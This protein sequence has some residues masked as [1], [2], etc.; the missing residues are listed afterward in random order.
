MKALTLRHLRPELARE[1]EREA[2]EAGTSLS[3]A[4]VSLL[5]QATGLVKSRKPLHHDFDRFAG[6]WS[7]EQAK[8]F[9]KSLSRL[10]S[11]DKEMWK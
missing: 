4:V 1:I 6:S 11:I 9:D 2:H 8:E 10:R 3:G 7:V 5:E